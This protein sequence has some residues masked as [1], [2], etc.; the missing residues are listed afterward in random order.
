M[1]TS[2]TVPTA[3]SGAPPSS[4]TGQTP[5]KY[6]RTFE[7]DIEAFKK[8]RIP[9]FAPL[10]EPPTLAQ[11]P[12]QPPQT[13]VP[14]D[15]APPG[16]P[17]DRLPEKFPANQTAEA[18]PKPPE[19]PLE[20]YAGDFSRRMQETHASRATVLAAQQD[21]LSGAPH[22]VLEK[23]PDN[24]NMLYVIA[25]AVL[26]LMGTAGTYIAYTRYL[27]SVE[28]VV[29]APVVSAPIFV[30]ERE[31]ILSAAPSDVWQVVTQSAARP[32]ALNAVRLLYMDPVTTTEDDVFSALQLPAPDILLRNVNAARSMAGVIRSGSG[33]SP[34]F[35]L[36][37]ASYRD[38]FAGMLAWEPTMPRDL[39]ALFFVPPPAFSAEATSS[40]QAAASIATTSTSSPQTGPAQTIATTTQKTSAKAA[41]GAATTPEFHDEIVGNHDV[42]IYRDAEGRTLLYGYWNQETLVIARDP[43]AFVDILGRLATSR[44]QN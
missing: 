42:R 39:G 40:P 13:P 28:P 21:A 34:F 8:G 25:A 7:G 12:I 30:D 16:N 33:Q 9:N 6:I 43:A 35:I 15:T 2:P 19:S 20:T 22:A 23:S 24:R 29:L 10:K 1:D 37:V 14:T 27:A 44:A 36:S 41:P 11:N 17:Q 31:Q 4:N 5:E 26:L 38:T 3:A 32:L 18:K